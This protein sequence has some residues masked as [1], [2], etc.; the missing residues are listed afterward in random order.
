[1]CVWYC[2]YLCVCF[3][4]YS[5][6]CDSTFPHAITVNTLLCG[7]QSLPCLWTTWTQ[8]RLS[9]LKRL[10]ETPQLNH[11][12]LHVRPIPGWYICCPIFLNTEKKICP[13]NTLLIFFYF[14]Y[15]QWDYILIQNSFFIPVISKKTGVRLHMSASLEEV[16]LWKHS[17]MFQKVP[18]H[19]GLLPFLFF[20]LSFTLQ[21]LSVF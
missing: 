5:H 15:Y 13:W 7:L 19:Y 12:R 18:E 17:G 2:T 8:N 1:M 21:D 11:K 10:W 14:I 20:W 9:L 16:L 4:K 6:R 3:W